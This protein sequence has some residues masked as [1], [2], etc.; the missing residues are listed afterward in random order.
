M[1][2]IA[3]TVCRLIEKYGTA[4][5]WEICDKM[6]IIVHE[7]ELPG[8]INGFASSYNGVSFIV[9]NKL[10]DHFEKKITLAHELGHIILHG[11]TNSIN[12]SMNTGFCT[13]KLEREAD[14]FAAHLLF[15]DELDEINSM[16]TVTAEDV[17]RLTHMPVQ[18]VPDAFIG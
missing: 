1:K 9:L 4:D 7:H 8:H 13:S 12:L 17:A 15:Y 5:P 14:C 10:P 6:G 2:A 11:C 18:M 3:N 16:E